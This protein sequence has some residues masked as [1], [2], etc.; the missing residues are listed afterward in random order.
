MNPCN[1]I[2]IKNRNSNSSS[3]WG[4]RGSEMSSLAF[5]RPSSTVRTLVEHNTLSKFSKCYI[6]IH[7]MLKKKLVF[8][9]SLGGAVIGRMSQNQKVKKI[10]SLPKMFKTFIWIK[11]HYNGIVISIKLMKI[12]SLFCCEFP[13]FIIYQHLYVF[14]FFFF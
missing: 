9:S 2:L 11:N 13:G 4:K 14:L 1:G 7:L 8:S 12:I 6:N 10:L 3:R 5:E